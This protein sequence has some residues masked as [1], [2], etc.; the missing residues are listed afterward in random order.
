MKAYGL[1]NDNSVQ[2]V[3]EAES[4]LE[5]G[6]LK[7]FIDGHSGNG[8][9]YGAGYSSTSWDIGYGYN[10]VSLVSYDASHELTQQATRSTQTPPKSQQKNARKQ[11]KLEQTK[12]KS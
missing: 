5:R 8:V 6:L 2:I 7:R 3:V 11:P 9:S 12:E 1:I 4:N 10:T